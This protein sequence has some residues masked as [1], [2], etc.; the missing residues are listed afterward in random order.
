MFSLG[1]IMFYILCGYLPFDSLFM[2]EITSSTV[3]CSYDMEGREWQ[4]VSNDA[5][6]LISKLLC[7]QDKRITVN[8]ALK[9]PWLKRKDELKSATKR[10]KI[11]KYI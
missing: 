9:H 11:P 1:V 4:M 7:D 3:N 10:S 6:D 5:K 2:E 8:Q